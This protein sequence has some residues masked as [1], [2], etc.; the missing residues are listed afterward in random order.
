MS[1]P[2]SAGTLPDI[3]FFDLET[4][5]LMPAERYGITEIGA[6]VIKQGQ[7]AGKFQTYVRPIDSLQYNQE[8]LDIQGKDLEFLRANGRHEIEAILGFR[9]WVDH[10]FPKGCLMPYA[11][12]APFDM[13]YIKAAQGRT[14]VRPFGVGYCDTKEHIRM[15]QQRKII[16]QFA[17]HLSSAAEYFKITNQQAH[18]ALSDAIT[19]GLIAVKAWSLIQQHGIQPARGKR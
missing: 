5:G 14:G 13:A 18:S 3:L 10:H 6:C 8:A 7:V 11:W 15:L 2:P 16:P 1:T 9:K 17:L 19:G 4:G 12:N